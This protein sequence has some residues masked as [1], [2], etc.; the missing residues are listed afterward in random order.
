MAEAGA[1]AE[2]VRRFWA[3]M[4]ASRFAEIAPLLADD[5]VCD[6]P[7]TRER[8]RG[9]AN[10]VALNAAYPGTGRI[11]VE[12]LVAAADEVVTQCRVVWGGAD[13]AAITFFT[14]RDGRIARMVE[15]WPEPY[16]PP[17]WRAGSPY[18]EPLP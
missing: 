9:A 11:V 16:A 15:W 2:A 5:L 18:L 7:L 3:L 10:F 13:D 8:I 14:L 6:W 12:R 4:G 17:A 1:N